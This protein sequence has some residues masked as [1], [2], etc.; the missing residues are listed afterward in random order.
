MS[1]RSSVSEKEW[2]SWRA[3]V[4]MRRELDRALG[5]RL[6]ADGGISA[7]DY[8]VLLA[9]WEAPERRLR[10]TRLGDLINWEKSRV[11]HQ[12]TRMES[13]GLIERMDCDDDARGKWV[14]LT[15]EGRRAVL[16][17]V[18]DHTA[19]LREYFFDLLSPEE[20][21]TLTSLSDRVVGAIDPAICR[22]DPE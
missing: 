12:L 8:S 10:A 16:S 5:E 20:L 22:E 18:R 9:L 15:A 19:A 13:R 14:V 7:A 3:F 6:Q 11:S 17:T 1:D 4:R 2:Q 21:G